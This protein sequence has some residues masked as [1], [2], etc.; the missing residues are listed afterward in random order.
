MED[1]V[2]AAKQ[3]C[4]EANRALE[5][6]TEEEYVKENVAMLQDVLYSECLSRHEGEM[7]ALW[8]VIG[9]YKGKTHDCY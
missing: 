1:C 4:S 5:T 9:A 6:E 7:L 8:K 2:E 3:A